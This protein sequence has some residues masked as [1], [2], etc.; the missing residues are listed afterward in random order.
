MMSPADAMARG[1]VWLRPFQ[2]FRPGDQGYMGFPSEKIRD[3]F[4]APGMAEDGA[5]VVVW[6]NMKGHPTWRGAFR[7]ILQIAARPGLASSHA[8]AAGEA[9]RRSSSSAYLHAVPVVRAWDADPARKAMMKGIIPSLWPDF[10]RITGLRSRRMDPG[11][12]PNILPRRI[13]EVSVHGQPPVTPGPF[14]KA[15]SILK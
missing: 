11:E 13:R 10:T 3:D 7:G 9:Q 12:I 4:L 1:Q 8:S 14:V 15:E 5:L 2:E 6:I